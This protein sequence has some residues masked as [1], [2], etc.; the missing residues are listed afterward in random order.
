MNR[1][2]ALQLIGGSVVATCARGD[3]KPAS[4][5]AVAGQPEGARAGHEVLDGGGNVVDAVVTAALVAAVVAVQ[6]TGPGGYGGHM[7]LAL[8]GGK[9]ITCIDF[10]TAAPAAAT[11]DVYPLNDRGAVKDSANTFGWRAVGVPGVLA[12][13]QFALE[14]YGTRKFGQLAQPA[15][16][17]CRDGFPLETGL[18]NAIRGSR[19]RLSA[20]PASAKLFF[21]GGEPLKT[22][23]L[24]RNPDLAAMLEKLAGQDSVEAF[25]RG[26]IAERIA[27]EMQKHGGLLTAADLAAYRAR[28]VEPLRLDWNGHSIYIAP[29]TAGGATTLQALAIVKA[30]GELPAGQTTHAKLEALRLAWQDRLAMFGDPEKGPVPVERL[31]SETHTRVQARLAEAA[32]RQGR[33]LPPQTD[34]RPTGGTIHLSAADAHGNLAALTLTH[35][36]SFGARVTVPGLGLILGHG[37]TRFEPKPGHPNSVG[38]GKRPL[39]NMCPTIVCKDG[40]PVLAVGAR[41][42]RRIPNTVFEVLLEF[43]GRGKLMDVALNAGRLH[44]EGGLNVDLDPKCTDGDVEYLKKIGFAADRGPGAFASAVLYDPATGRC[45]AA[46]R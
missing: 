36:D 29:L 18:A 28:E 35:G 21:E 23:A 37:M 41:G 19:T 10:N 9:K 45:R 38:P 1:R 44:T 24:Y 33:P 8:S 5:G 6:Q 16:R 14:R 27:A 40:R 42:G 11:P 3:D 46:S 2:E 25:Y 31:L 43:V 22:G 32:A 17:Y 34:G 26:E 13:L 15:I 7:T 12:G 30:L 20:D 4:G 39:H